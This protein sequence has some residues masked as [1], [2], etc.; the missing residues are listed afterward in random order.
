[1][2]FKPTLTSVSGWRTWGKRIGPY[3]FVIAY[4]TQHDRWSASIKEDCKEGYAFYSR[5]GEV[6]SYVECEKALKNWYKTRN[7]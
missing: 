3:T 1:M 2:K 4:N 7:N 5:E 6:N